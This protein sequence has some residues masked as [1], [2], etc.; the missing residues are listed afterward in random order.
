MLLRIWI[1]VLHNNILLFIYV[2]DINTVNGNGDNN[3]HTNTQIQ[4]CYARNGN[5]YQRKSDLF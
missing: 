3:K 1:F 2:F 5:I 4:K